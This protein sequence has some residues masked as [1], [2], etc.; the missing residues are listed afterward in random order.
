MSAPYKHLGIQY[1]PLGGLNAENMLEYLKEPN[2]PIIGG[3]WIVKN[4]LVNNKDWAGITARARDV[5]KVLMLNTGSK[6]E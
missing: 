1:F 6:N 5:T 3:S 2:V 4:D